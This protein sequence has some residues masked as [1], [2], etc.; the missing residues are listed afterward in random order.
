MADVRPQ[1]NEEAVGANHPTK[2]D[3]INRAYDVEHFE[4]GSHVI[5]GSQAA[6]DIFMIM[7]QRWFGLL[8]QME[9]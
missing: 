7:G 1:Y 3:V 6:G 8:N 2:T 9:K 5:A 4:D